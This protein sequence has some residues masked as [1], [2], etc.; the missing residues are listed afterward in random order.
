MGWYGVSKELGPVYA[1]VINDNVPKPMREL[2]ASALDSYYASLTSVV[3]RGRDRRSHGEHH[4]YVN[5]STAAM[6]CQTSVRVIRRV[7]N[8]PETRTLRVANVERCPILVDKKQVLAWN[9]VRK[10]LIN[11]R[12]AQDKTGFPEYALLALADRGHIRRESGPAAVMAG[13]ISTFGAIWFEGAT[14]DAFTDSI[15]ALARRCCGQDGVVRLSVAL[16]ASRQVGV[17]IPILDAVFSGRLEVY[18]AE[19]NTYDP[20]AHGLFARSGQIRGLLSSRVQ[21]PPLLGWNSDRIITT[22]AASE[23]LNTNETAVIRLLQ[24]K[25]GIESVRRKGRQHPIR[26]SVQAFA[27]RYMLG[28]E[29]C[30]VLRLAPSHVTRELGKYGVQ[31]A[32]RIQEDRPVWRRKEIEALRQY[33]GTMA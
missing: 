29:V 30:R 26:R 21:I 10:G 33:I 17:W 15:L 27:S 16:H 23:Y 20:I 24:I 32:F 14:I 18:L 2:L 5:M 3:F 9:E 7:L 1:F 31:P 4:G 6:L 19:D 22:L 8:F 25:N 13:R 11:V 12:Q 28:G